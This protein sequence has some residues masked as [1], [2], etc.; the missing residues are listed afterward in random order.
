VQRL[1]HSLQASQHHQSAANCSCGTGR[2]HAGITRALA[3]AH[4]AHERV[5][6]CK[7]EVGLKEIFQ[8]GYI[9]QRGDGGSAGNAG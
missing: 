8:A 3:R 5:W 9:L 6:V 1:Y 4:Q 2:R 7:V